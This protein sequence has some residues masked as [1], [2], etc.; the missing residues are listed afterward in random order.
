MWLC[1]CT[2]WINAPMHTEKSH[3]NP[4]NLCNYYLLY[5]KGL[6]AHVTMFRILRW[7]YY[8]V[9]SRWDQCNH[10]YK[11]KHESQ[12]CEDR[13]R[14]ERRRGREGERRERLEDGLL[15]ALKMEERL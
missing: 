15:L 8:P 14:S 3:P 9:L 10:N 11:R 7:Q 2:R 1:E 4:Q 5:P 6:S 13:R 12:R